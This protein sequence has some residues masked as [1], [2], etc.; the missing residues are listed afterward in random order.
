M[1]PW[2]FL[3]LRQHDLDS[4]GYPPD[5]GSG[6]EPRGRWRDH[7]AGFPGGGRHSRIKLHDFTAECRG[8]FVFPPDGLVD[9]L[10][11]HGNA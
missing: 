2:P 6:R 8:L 5:I 3:D 1:S 10:A 11:V 4:G 7:P 9:L